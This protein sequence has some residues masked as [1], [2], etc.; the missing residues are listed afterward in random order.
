MP[1]SYSPKRG[2]KFVN[3]LVV[4]NNGGHIRGEFHVSSNASM[5]VRPSDAINESK[6]QLRLL[7]AIVAW[8][9]QEDRYVPFMVLMKR[10]I[11]WIEFPPDADWQR[12]HNHQ[13]PGHQPIT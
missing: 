7:N 12:G 4:M 11:A 6:D 2:T 3:V 5:S 1:M 8:H 10:N 13:D 9:G